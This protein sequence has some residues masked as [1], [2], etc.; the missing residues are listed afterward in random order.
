VLTKK[1]EKVAGNQY[2][3]SA[4]PDEAEKQTKAKVLAN[5]VPNPHPADLATKANVLA[6][7][8][9]ST[10]QA[11]EWEPLADVPADDFEAALAAN[12]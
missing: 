1:I 6:N 2:T 10:Q 7:A 8:G 9:I 12:Q 5:T 11:S 4:F 3:K